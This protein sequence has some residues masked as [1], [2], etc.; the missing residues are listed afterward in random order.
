MT[1]IHTATV[2]AAD[3]YRAVINAALF[4][5]TDDTLPSLTTIHMVAGE[6]GKLLV[7]ATN[8]YVASRET[9]DLID[10][11]AY[12]SDW[13]TSRSETINHLAAAHDVPKP[14]GHD[15]RTELAVDKEHQAM[16]KAGADHEHTIRPVAATDL[17]VLVT[18]KGLVKITKMLKQLEV[19]N[20]SPEFPLIVIE[21]TEENQHASFTLTRHADPDQTLRTDVVTVGEF[22]RLDRLW[23]ISRDTE[24]ERTPDF[25]L[26]QKWLALLAKVETDEKAAYRPVQFRAGQDG[27]PVLVKIGD[28]F[29]AIVIPIRKAE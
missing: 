7:E 24:D 13:F 6:P 20:Y 12:D 27:K 9:L 29:E 10:P 5:S 4:A 22:P 15:S 28:R 19:A 8:R 14:E 23:P 2:P 16:H 1:D 18:A 25:I 26:A 21:W 17:D 3:F 11:A